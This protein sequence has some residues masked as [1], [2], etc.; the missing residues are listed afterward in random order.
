MLYILQRN[1][2]SEGIHVINCD[3]VTEARDPLPLRPRRA[4]ERIVV[5]VKRDF[6]MHAVVLKTLLKILYS[7]THFHYSSNYTVRPPCRLALQCSIH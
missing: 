2:W 6:K 5:D 3:I 4:V 1:C 7:N